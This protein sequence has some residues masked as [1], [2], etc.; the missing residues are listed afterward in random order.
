M[1][2]RGKLCKQVTGFRIV[3]AVDV[4]TLCGKKI[5]NLV[6]FGTARCLAF[7]MGYEVNGTELHGINKKYAAAE[8]WFRDTYRSFLHLHV[9]KHA[10]I[11]ENSK[12][13]LLWLS[14]PPDFLL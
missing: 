11:V 8:I 3:A 1:P 2:Y 6:L 4:A 12:V 7:E 13:L 5:A 9:S 14:C 10:V